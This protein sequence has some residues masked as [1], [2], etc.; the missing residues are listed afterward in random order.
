VPASERQDCTWGAV[1]VSIGTGSL[2]A[3]RPI[4]AALLVLGLAPVLACPPARAQVLI[5]YLFGEKLST[6][7]FN[8]GF[9]VGANFSTLTGFD[10]A[11]RMNRTAFGLFADWRYSE[12]FHLG[13]A[14]LPFAGRGAQN[15]A[16]EPTGDPAFDSQVAGRR[17][18]R[19]F[20]YV[21]IS[22]LMKWAPKREEGIRFGAGPS[23]GIVTGA[24][25][26]YDAVTPGGLSYTLER[27]LGGSVPG[28]DFGLSVEAEWRLSLLS[29][30]ARYTQGL[31]DMRADGAR[32]PSYTRVLTGTGRIYLGKKPGS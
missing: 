18:Q 6:P 4:R 12:H 22:A 7:T 26:R 14:V 28:V 29:I 10:D 23:L 19:S 16:A 30:A 11:R 24:R 1:Q 8:M 25:D 20:D 9:E 17:M 3:M 21:E 27:D 13:G 5:G 32:D 2:P 31:T 15:L